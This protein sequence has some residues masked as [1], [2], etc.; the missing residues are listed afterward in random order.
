LMVLGDEHILTCYCLETNR[1]WNSELDPADGAVSSSRFWPL[2]GGLVT[3][4]YRTQRSGNRL[5]VHDQ[6]GGMV[7]AAYP[8]RIDF[9]DEVVGLPDGRSMAIRSDSRA[10]I[11]RFD[12]PTQPPQPDGH[13]DE[14]WTVAY[15]P[16]GTYFATGSDDTDDPQTLKLWEV[17]TGRMVKGW[18]AHDATTGAVAFQPGG[19]IIATAG[20]GPKENLR[21]WDAATG[22]P[23]ATLDGHTDFV[24]SVAFSPDGRLLASAGS[25]RIIRLWDVASRHC[26][27]ELSGHSDAIRQVAFSPDGR[28]L[29]SAGNDHTVR[30][31]DMEAPEK[32]WTWGG[33]VKISGVSFSPDGSMLAWVHEDGVVQRLDL[34]EDQKLTPLYAEYDELRCLAFSPDGRIL[35]TAGKSGNVHLWDPLSGQEL[36]T[37]EG[38]P[39]QVNALSFSPDGQSLAVC[40]HDG[41]VRLFRSR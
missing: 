35:A 5:K 21:L 29:A 28:R 32:E 20:F 25:D 10:L 15:S 6:A 12:P 14:A 9:P 7:R 38:R 18:K 13:K 37:L 31:W 41:A 30:L 27:R 40:W 19:N 26:V 8:C 1:S 4:G 24:R 16:D 17:A 33:S 23:L 34:A 2:P 36:L 22:A 39:C 11:W 3:R